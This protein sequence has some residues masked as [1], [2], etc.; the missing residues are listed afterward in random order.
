MTA[1]D[2]RSS[3]APE[4]A[5][6][7]G[8]SSLLIAA[9]VLLL[10]AASLAFVSGIVLARARE[11]AAITSLDLWVCPMHPEVQSRAPGECPICHMAFERTQG[12]TR[13]ASYANVRHGSVEMVESRMFADRVR[14]P[15]WVGSDGTIEAA[16]Y[17]DDLLRLVPRERGSFFRATAPAAGLGVH[18]A[19]ESASPWDGSTSRVRFLFDAAPR[20]LQSG[21]VGWLELNPAPRKLLVVP[22]SAVLY[23]ADGSH[24]LVPA[25][26]DGL[27]FNK[28]TIEV[29]RTL[30]GRTAE[31]RVSPE[32]IVVLSGL[33][34]DERVIA[35][36][37]FISDAE[38]RLSVA[39]E[40]AEGVFQ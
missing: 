9:R 39:R 15:A 22:W 17:K 7:S 26:E 35:G 25:Q 8:A 28:R 30:Y 23:S 37:T 38:R 13:T 40:Q 16:L 10:L 14:A 3:Q 21:E 1:L 2:F 11:R 36:D 31:G 33:R 32:W 6:P 19:S 5:K 24:V 18:L 34:A 20:E 27:G 4:G 12:A 29:G